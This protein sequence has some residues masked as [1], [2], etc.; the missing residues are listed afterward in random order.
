MFINLYGE[1]KTGA[2]ASQMCFKPSEHNP[3]H[4]FFSTKYGPLRGPPKF[5]Q[6]IGLNKVS[7]PVQF[8]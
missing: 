5:G 6:K 4:T 7:F 8:H 3:V 2:S 1:I